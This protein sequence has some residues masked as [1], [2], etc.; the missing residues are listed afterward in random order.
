M[1]GKEAT[2]KIGNSFVN[3]K[4]AMASIAEAIK[5]IFDSAEKNR[6]E[7]ETIRTAL[8]SLGKIAKVENVMVTNSVFKGDKTVNMNDEDEPVDE[9]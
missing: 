1:P 6:V 3:S 9:V 4:E 8:R 2:I 7:Q 5:T